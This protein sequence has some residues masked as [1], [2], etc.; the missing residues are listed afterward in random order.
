V[1]SF[2]G[3]I[4]AELAPRSYAVAIRGVIPGTRQKKT[5]PTERPLCVGPRATELI[6]EYFQFYRDKP[7]KQLKGKF[8]LCYVDTPFGT[9]EIPL[10]NLLYATARMLEIINRRKMDD[11]I[12]IT[13]DVVHAA[14]DVLA[15]I[16][17]YMAND[18]V[19]MILEADF[20]IY[21]LNE[22]KSEAPRILQEQMSSPI[23]DGF[24]LRLLRTLFE[25]GPGTL[26]LEMDDIRKA[27]AK[28][29]AKGGKAGRPWKKFLADH[30]KEKN[31]PGRPR[32]T[33]YDLLLEKRTTNLRME[34]YGKLVRQLD[35]AASVPPDVMRNRLKSAAA[36]RRKKLPTGKK[37]V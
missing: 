21:T 28:V 22:G 15:R 8:G 33:E 25:E 2:H 10:D 6:R 5:D 3:S 16:P 18:L 7:S 17:A 27:F 12:E 1:V 24:R 31:K 23:G 32:S 4:V 35:A 30:F 36:Y 19:G 20:E 26:C 9:L 11:K 29:I 14:L 34:T 37:T 13:G